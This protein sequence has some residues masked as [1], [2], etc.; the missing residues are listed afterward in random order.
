[1]MGTN[2]GRKI[3]I[4]MG[5]S[6]FIGIFIPPL[7]ILG[8]FLFIIPGVI[9]TLAPT[10]FTYWSLAICLTRCVFDEN[11]RSS[12]LVAAIIVL[13]SG[14]I[15][16]VLFNIPIWKELHDIKQSDIS[17]PY[18]I[19]R[20]NAI[21]IH[22]DNLQLDYRLTNQILCNSLCQRLLYNGA[23]K[24][25]LISHGDNSL[26]TLNNNTI[27]TAFHIEKKKNCKHENVINNKENL[28]IPNVQMHLLAGECLVRTEALLSEA[29]IIFINRDIV[30]TENYTNYWNMFRDVLI[31]DQIEVRKKENNQYKTVYRYT[32]AKI[33]PLVI[34]LS[35][36]YWPDNVGIG[37]FHYES[38]INDGKYTGNNLYK[39]FEA[40]V[41]QIFGEFIQEIPILPVDKSRALLNSILDDPEIEPK[42]KQRYFLWYMDFLTDY[43]DKKKYYIQPKDTELLIKAINNMEIKEFWPLCRII[44]SQGDDKLLELRPFIFK[45]MVKSEN[46]GETRGLSS[47]LAAF[48]PKYLEE[49]KKQLLESHLSEEKLKWIRDQ[50]LGKF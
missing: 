20:A 16:S 19:D 6:A 12:F 5:V 46:Y 21:A 1:M 32:K 11:H 4:F 15:I 29:D 13:L 27:L 40:Q 18:S 37:F 24:K 3:F 10:I 35:F 39:E 25:V 50:S 42:E 48:S 49:Y 31:A 9:L 36:G 47:A 26:E 2:S 30:R 38:Y 23:A 34:P 17:L 44:Y 22:A 45:R 28:A 7:V 41:N 14:C 8:Y 43:N 33:E